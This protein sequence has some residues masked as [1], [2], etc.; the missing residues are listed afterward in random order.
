MRHHVRLAVNGREF[1]VEGEDVFLPLADWL[2]TLR[3]A[4]GT[5]IVCAEGDCGACTVL[6]G[7]PAGGTIDYRSLNAC[8]LFLYQLDGAHVI[9]VEGLG[10]RLNPVQESMVENHGAQCGY[11]T[12]GFVMAMTGLA[13]SG[14]KLDESAVKDGL[15]GNLCR[16][17]GYEPIIRAALAVQGRA[18]TSLDELYPPAVL[19][20]MLADDG[21][22][23]RVE[24]GAR[25]FAAPSNLDGALRFKAEV[26]DAV[27]V[28]GGTDVG[29][30]WNKRGVQPRAIL[31]LSRL[32]GLDEIAVDD[33]QL[34][35]GARVTLTD[36]DARIRELLPELHATLG[37][38]GSPQIRN[39]ATLAG[40]IANASPV[41]D[42]LPFLFVMDAE[43]E[44]ASLRGTRRIAIKELY[45]G[46]KQLAMEPGELITRIVI[47]IPASDETLRLYK[48]SKRRD[49]D[50]A[51]FTAAIRMSVVDGSMRRVRIAYGGVAPVVLRLPGTEKL[52]E[53][54]EP[55]RELFLRAGKVARSE[56]APISDVRGTAEYRSL[57]AERILM[58]FFALELATEAAGV[59]VSA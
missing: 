57:L 7:R 17:T 45:R 44:V 59:R 26:P 43:V 56:I 4:T 22:E 40:N 53:G 13:A 37:V 30:A 21:D 42:T 23:V 11:C 36:L 41:A 20:T 25:V 12:P 19:A 16:C 52:L 47:P 9:T 39:A 54:A 31:S 34:T 10:A 2:R 28:Q 55:S 48:I 58:K 49:L 8:I 50:I 15:T 38:F 29:V 18:G 35:I 14:A 6:V 1:R 46:Y 3:R 33:S 27:V 32:R 24:A 5:K 51:S